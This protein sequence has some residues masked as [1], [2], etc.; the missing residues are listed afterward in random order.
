MRHAR[1]DD[2]NRVEP[3][4]E[5]LRAVPGLTERKRGIFYKGAKAFLHFHEHDGALYADVRGAEDWERMDAA[6]RGWTK[7]AA[8]AR[9]LARG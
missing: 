6:R 5:T 9:L 2:L 4:L 1:P 8:R 3:L 7:I